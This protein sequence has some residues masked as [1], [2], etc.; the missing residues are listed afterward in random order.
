MNILLW[1]D[2]QPFHRDSCDILTK[3][4]SYRYLKMLIQLGSAAHR[5][6]G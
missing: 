1:N 2:K 5:N 6:Y 3:I 4:I